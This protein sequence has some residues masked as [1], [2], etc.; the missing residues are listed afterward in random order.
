MTTHPFA[1]LAREKRLSVL[2][3]ILA[4]SLTLTVALTLIGEP[5][6]N[7]IAPAGIVSFEFAKDAAT[8]ERIVTSWTTGAASMT[9]ATGASQLAG[10]SA[11]ESVK[12]YAALSLGLDYLYLFV[13]STA[14]GFACAWVALSLRERGVSG[15][16]VTAGIW[17]AW[18]QWLAALFDAM[19]NYV[20]LRALFAS[21]SDAMMQFARA[22][23]TLKF[24]LVAF[25]LLYVIGGLLARLL[26]R[27]RR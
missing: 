27:A 13:Y 18:A 16:P 15:F 22:C 20:L 24:A 3:P 17:L 4:L 5:L 14:I 21:V 23:A 6:K 19:E 8:A 2:L 1:N 10:V 12:P 26:A 9:E 25:G 11:F 7:D